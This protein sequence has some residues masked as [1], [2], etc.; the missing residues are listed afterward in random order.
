MK[1]AVYLFIVLIASGA[2]LFSQAD[3]GSSKK[4]KIKGKHKIKMS[5]ARHEYLNGNPRVALNIFREVHRDI[6][7]NALINYRVAECH[8]AINNQELAI[9][10][11]KN[12]ITINPSVDKQAYFWYG[13]SLHRKGHLDEALQAFEQFKKSAKPK[14]IK[15]TEVD[16][17]IAKV[18]EAKLQMSRPLN[19]PITN[20]GENVNSRFDDYAP[21]I[22]ADGKTMIFTSRRPDTQGGKVDEKSDNKY[23]EDIYITHFDWASNS[24][25]EA[26]PIPGRINS[27][28]HDAS[29]GISK[30]GTMIFIYRNDGNLYIGDIFLSKISVSSGKWGNPKPLN[31][32]VNSSYFESSASLTADGK[33]LYFVSERPK[34]S[35]GQADIYVSQRISKYVWSEPKNLGPVV[36][37]K[38]DEIGVFIHPDGKTLFFSSKGHKNM[39]GYDIFMTRLQD[40]STWS[41]PVNLG[42]PINTVDDDLHFVLS[43]DYKTAYY[44][45]IK[46]GGMGERD[47]YSIDFSSYDI[48]QGYGEKLSILKGKV[49]INDTSLSN[50]PKIVVSDAQSG[51]V[52]ASVE[53]DEETRE[54]FLIVPGD[55]KYKV[56][57]SA[58]GHASKTEEMYVPYTADKTF[59]MEHVFDLS[60]Q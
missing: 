2:S 48:T 9:E 58:S 20:L 25:S 40:D 22:T 57:A 36:N 59:V 14:L 8:F 37:T 45:S 1:K 12:A 60:S 35:V 56:S 7:N 53:T 26:E 44:S 38:E 21:S 30:D 15:E 50:V 16:R 6:P 28:G 23:F 55:K 27:P 18:H 41:E 33:T 24:W 11:F 46:P 13:R 31:K 39:G 5:Q 4:Q 29:L 10:Y 49:L 47:I 3:E 32:A 42:Y 51:K 54:F 34:G 43:A 52:I 17:Y 19:L